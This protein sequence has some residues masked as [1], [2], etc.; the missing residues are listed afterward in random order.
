M[1]YLN[2]RDIC[3]MES[4]LHTFLARNHLNIAN[5]LLRTFLASFSF[6]PSSE[7]SLATNRL[8]FIKSIHFIYVKKILQYSWGTQVQKY[9]S[10]PWDEF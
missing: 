2:V 7:I 8:T 1:R 3:V 5:E 6:F 10:F 9:I 4:K